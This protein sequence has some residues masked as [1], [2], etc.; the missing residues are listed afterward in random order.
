LNRKI[1]GLNGVA[2][3]CGQEMM[4][5]RAVRGVIR[6]KELRRSMNG[7]CVSAHR[8]LLTF[9][10][11]RMH[12]TLLLGPK[13]NGVGKPSNLRYAGATMF[14]FFA[15]TAWADVVAAGERDEPNSLFLREVEFEWTGGGR[16]GVELS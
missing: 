2:G 11:R 16:L 4:H 12:L 5:D 14:V 1:R 3:A 10:A 15:R 9:G 8:S 13:F 7:P 6:Q